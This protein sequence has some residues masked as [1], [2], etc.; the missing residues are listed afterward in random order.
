MTAAAYAKDLLYR[1]HPDKVEAEKKI[2]DILSG[3]HEVAEEHLDIA[4]EQLEIQEDAVKRKRSD[5][6]QCHQ[7]SASQLTAA[8]AG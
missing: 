1:I 8:T 4:K 5:K 6:E 7:L 3:L 2:G